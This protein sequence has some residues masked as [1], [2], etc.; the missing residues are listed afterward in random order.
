[1]ALARFGVGKVVSVVH[2]AGSGLQGFVDLSHDDKVIQASLFRPAPS[3]TVQTPTTA[4]FRQHHT[5]VAYQNLCL[6]T[7]AMLRDMFISLLSVPRA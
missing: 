4:G 7:R 3:I 5:D 6:I 1:M 2:R